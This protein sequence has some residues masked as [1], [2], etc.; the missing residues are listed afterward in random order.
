VGD[1]VREA[2]DF[3]CE[4]NYQDADEDKAAAYFHLTARQAARFARQGQVRKL[5][6]FHI[7]RKYQGDFKAS[8]REAR[9]EFSRVD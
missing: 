5:I 3:Y 4:S 8:F 6:L 7:S 9:E 2:D 1:L